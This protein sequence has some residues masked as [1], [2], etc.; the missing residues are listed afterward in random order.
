MGEANNRCFSNLVVGYQSAFD[1]SG[2]EAVVRYVEHVINPAGNPVIAIF[3]T[4]GA[5]TGKVHTFIS[6]EIRLFEALMIA[7]NRA[8]LARPAVHNHEIAVSLSFQ[9]ITFAVDKPGLYAKERHCRRAR[10]QIHRTGQW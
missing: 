3:I 10:L 7:V 5:V 8:H 9:Y 1:L 6:A 4:T 2:T